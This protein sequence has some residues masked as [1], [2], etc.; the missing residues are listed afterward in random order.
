[1]TVGTLAAVLGCQ[2]ARPL[3]TQPAGPRGLVL[4]FPGVVNVETQMSDLAGM[5][6]RRHPGLLARVQPWGPALRSI[7]NLTDV[8]GNRRRAAD[9][10]REIAEYRRREPEAIIDLVGFSGGGGFAALVVEALPAEV[11][12]D[13]LVLVAAALSRSFPFEAALLPR[14][15]EFVVCYSSPLDVQVGLGTRWLGNVDGA[16]S[17]SIGAVGPPTSDGRVLHVRWKSDMLRQLHFG[18]HLS[19]LSRTWQRKYLVPALD[20]ALDADALRARLGIP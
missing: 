4:I 11:Q 7:K 20:P 3:T 17:P 1:M 15:R 9:L 12:I 14:V 8:E 2:Q 10:A 19:Y 13:R 5:L 16:K 18:N 6:N